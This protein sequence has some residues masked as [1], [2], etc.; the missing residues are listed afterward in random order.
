M[1]NQ[2]T[3]I[4]EKLNESLEQVEA[5]GQLGIFEMLKVQLIRNLSVKEKLAADK[6]FVECIR[7]LMDNDARE[8]EDVEGQPWR[9]VPFRG[10]RHFRERRDP[11]PEPLRAHR[12]EEVLKILRKGRSGLIHGAL[13]EKRVAGVTNVT[14]P[15]T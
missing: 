10:R 9:Q 2:Y 7:D 5:A 11:R 14:D 13:D 4:C 15:G 12:P 1:L 8:E 6:S 3:A